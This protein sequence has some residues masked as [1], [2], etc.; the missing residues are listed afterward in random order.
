[1]PVTGSVEL[2][3]VAALLRN[4]H[5]VDLEKEL[6]QSQRAAVRPLSRE[7]KAEALATLPG[8]GGYGATM[9]RAIRVTT[10]VGL[11]RGTLTARVYASGKVEHRDVAAVNAGRIRH[12]LF[13]RRK[14]W[15]VTSVASGFVDRPVARLIDR[16]RDEAAAGVDR[17]LQKI[18]RG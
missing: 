6:K 7:I 12:P 16:V 1:V 18:A 15:Y 11:G 8:R 17:V 2:R 14:Y 10:S 9:S 13:G 5:A 4:A 3:H